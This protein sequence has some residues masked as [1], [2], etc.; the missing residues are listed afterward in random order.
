MK[1]FAKITLHNRKEQIKNEFHNSL[2]EAFSVKY[3]ESELNDEVIGF[4]N[5]LYN[6]DLRECWDAKRNLACRSETSQKKYEVPR[7]AQ[8]KLT[9]LR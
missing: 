5:L 2:N 6:K 7:I 4:N 8:F 3:S 1:Q 9:I